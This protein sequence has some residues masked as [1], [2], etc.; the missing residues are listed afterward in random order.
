[1]NDVLLVYYS[2]EGN[3]SFVADTVKAFCPAIM[4]ER[5]IAENEPPKKGFG[6]FFLGGKSALLQS[7]PHL[8][9]VQSSSDDFAKIILAFPVWAGTF[10]PAIG[11][12]LKSIGIKNK[13]VY[14]IAC[15]ASGNADK[16]IAKA[17]AALPDNTHKASLSLINPLKNKE[18]VEKQLTDFLNE[19]GLI[20]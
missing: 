11:A 13:E 2:F 10:P 14:V 1:M 12:Y 8:K 17:K 9:P 15:S 19:Q 5:L 3:T 7:D 20:E 6:K 4:T 18:T 16:A